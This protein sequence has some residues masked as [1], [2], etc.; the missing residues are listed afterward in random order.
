DGTILETEDI[1][2]IFS[3]TV[4][5]ETDSVK[6]MVEA[7]DPKAVITGLPLDASTLDV[8]K[9]DIVVTVET[10]ARPQKFT[11]EYTFSVVRKPI[12]GTTL[13]DLT[14]IDDNERELELS[15]SFS[16]DVTEYVVTVPYS[17][18][19]VTV[20]PEKE[21]SSAILEAPEAPVAVKVGDNEILS[22]V[23]TQTKIASTEYKVIVK[24]SSP[25]LETFT[26]TTM[27]KDEE[28]EKTDLNFNPA[29][30]SYNML[31]PFKAKN[32]K[33][34]AIL[35]PADKAAG[36]KVEV[37]TDTSSELEVGLNTVEVRITDAEG[38]SYNYTVNITRDELLPFRI[39]HEWFVTPAASFYINGMGAS[40]NGGINFGFTDDSEISLLLKPLRLG[41]GAF[42]HWA[43]G[44]YITVFSAGGYIRGGYELSTDDWYEYRWFLPTAFLPRID[45]GASY[46]HYEYSNVDKTMNQAAFYA[47]PGVRMNF[48]MPFAPDL[49]VGIDASYVLHIGSTLVDYFNLGLTVAF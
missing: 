48:I 15:P 42:G 12:P 30:D 32:I 47:S 16:P 33:L 4:P 36:A 43:T 19:T 40:F 41:A 37:L 38:N 28:L 45:L 14:I 46:M 21:D 3:V 1:D 13:K 26:A 31:V 49:V 9:N 23:T 39:E 11:E 6:I 44:N 5:F 10:T 20:N 8:G 18:Q 35:N 22:T 27:K 29:T 17:V 2:N 34:D 24:K 7:Q 25:A